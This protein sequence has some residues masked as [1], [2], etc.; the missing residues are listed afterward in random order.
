MRKKSCVHP[1]SS[2]SYKAGSPGA[3]LIIPTLNLLS[4]LICFLPTADLVHQS[5]SS[6]RLS[7]SCFRLTFN[8]T[9]P[10]SPTSTLSLS[11]RTHQLNNNNGL[12]WRRYRLQ[13][14]K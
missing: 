11:H 1:S 4:S 7:H 13:P 3:C 5:L 14:R 8:C 10:L 2:K 9:S 12:R 6:F